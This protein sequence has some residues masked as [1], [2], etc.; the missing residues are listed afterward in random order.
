MA[1]PSNVQRDEEGVPLPFV[2]QY[3][4]KGA[5]AV[6]VF[7][8]D[9]GSN[10]FGQHMPYCFPPFSMIDT[11]IAHLQNCNGKCVVILPDIMGLWFPKYKIGLR[12]SKRLAE[13]HSSSILLCFKNNSFHPF[14][15]KFPVVAA[16]LDFSK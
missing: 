16:L 2:S 8:V 7:S 4:V 11:F 1:S 12:K 6:D 14:R 13:R 15:S 3:V 10:T 9:L 5:T